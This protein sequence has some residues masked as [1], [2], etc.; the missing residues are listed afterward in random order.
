MG[1][2]LDRKFNI[3]FAD[4]AG[5]SVK[6]EGL[7]ELLEFCKDEARFWKERR[8][9]ID[10]AQRQ[11][12]PVIEFYSSFSAAVKNVEALFGKMD[13]LDDGQLQQQVNAAM[14]PIMSNS[15]SSWLWSGHALVDPF[16]ECH[17]KHGYVVAATFLN[18]IT[19][20]QVGNLNEYQTFL[21]VII[22]YEFTNQDSDLVKRRNGEK[23]S[24]GHLRN[25][26]AE[27]QTVLIG[28]VEDFKSQLHYWRD[29]QK[30]NWS[31]WVE[32]SVEEHSLRHKENKDEFIAY[33]DGC[34]VR[35][36]DLENTYHEKIR[37]E[38]PAEYWRRSARRL[39][40]QGGL[41]SLALITSVLLGF[42]YFSGFFHEWLE[43]KQMLVQLNTIQGVV[44]FGTILAV[45]AFLVRTLSR[46]TFSCF[47]LMRDAEER[48]QLT[49]LYLSLINDKKIDESARDIVLQALF[50]RSETGLLAS[51]SGPAMPGV[52]EIIRAASR[53][54]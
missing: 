17:K 26:L 54:R 8:E 27:T 40:I 25:Q 3:R 30:A 10:K 49:Y 48:E 33:M 35:I 53:T 51:E 37:L 45:Y 6:F 7:R 44:I 16:M 50:S 19:K 20:K 31:S 47:H 36:A 41:W 52:S 15:S 14:Q 22:A 42:V 39:G 18:Y 43:A 9:E 5:R 12:H 24:L 28:E 46:L 23:V 32:R 34:R 38:K 21:G 1:Q 29:E 11:I 4:T 2:K 13:E